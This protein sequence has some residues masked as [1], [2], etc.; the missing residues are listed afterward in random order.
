MRRLLPPLVLLFLA[1][2]APVEP[3]ACADHEPQVRL[4]RGDDVQADL[5]DGEPTTLVFGPQGGFHVLFG[6]RVVDPSPRV[7]LDVSV[8]APQGRVVDN[9]YRLRLD[10]LDEQGCVHGFDDLFGF[11][12]TSAIDPDARPPELLHGQTLLMRVQVEA[13]QG[14]LVDEV[15]VVG[16]AE[17]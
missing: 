5:V 11:I 3:E 12:D 16:Q 8:D 17:E 7:T 10:T 15:E 1:A 13:S 4:T 6:V 9:H 2:C 14:V